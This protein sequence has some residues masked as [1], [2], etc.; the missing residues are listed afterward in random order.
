MR[1][2][3][4]LFKLEIVGKHW[5]EE[6]SI[7][8]TGVL[9]FLLCSYAINNLENFYPLNFLRIKSVMVKSF[10]KYNFLLYESF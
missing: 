9:H 8:E 3:F 6:Y 10:L 4:S 5:K 7:I 2:L 1:N